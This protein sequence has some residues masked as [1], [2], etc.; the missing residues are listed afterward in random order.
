MATQ[1]YV[2]QCWTC[3]GEFDA[4]DSV[5]CSCDPRNPTRLCQFCLQCFCNAAEDY[6]KTFWKS[7]PEVLR[8]EIALL[9][10]AKGK[11]GEMLIR[12][13]L[14]TTDQLVKAIEYQKMRNLRM[15]EALVELGFVSRK[16]IDYFLS[17]QENVSTVNL[18]EFTP[19]AE[20]FA[21]LPP[22]FCHEKNVLPL[23]EDHVGDEVIVTVAMSDPKDV[24]LID[25]IQ[26]RMESK[27]IPY[28]AEMGAI[29]AALEKFFNK[30]EL[31]PKAEDTLD[32]KKA[33]QNLL[34]GGIKSKATDLYIEPKE[35]FVHISYRIDG[36][37]FKHKPFPISAYPVLLAEFRRTVNLPPQ[38]AGGQ[39]IESGRAVFSYQKKK[40]EITLQALPSPYGQSLGIK[41]ID[42]EEF[43]KDISALG[44]ADA[45]L[46]SLRR[47]LAAANGV[48]LVAGPVMNGTLTTMYSVIKHLSERG[49]RVVTI[50]SPVLSPLDEV[51]QIQV[52]EGQF[53]R[54]FQ[55]VLRTDPE[56]VVLSDLEDSELAVQVF[57]AGGKL[58]V[59]ALLEAQNA[60]D[61]LR[62]IFSSLGVSRRDAAASLRAIVSQ[63][64]IRK[65]CPDCRKESRIPP[66][67]LD[68]AGML[69]PGEKVKAFAGEG[70]AKCHH[71]G[72]RGRT[73]VFEVLLIS[74]ALSQAMLQGASEA[75]LV[76]L[77]RQAGM[78]SMKQRCFEAIQQ[79]ETTV[80][81]FEKAKF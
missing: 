22:R 10:G 62:E 71:T 17:R 31:A 52:S 11:L 80:E 81:E 72:Y 56:A 39:E 38:P 59:A 19:K 27:I 79:G 28:Q 53:A 64:L 74:E 42:R 37:L 57:R 5:W 65:I 60:E 61:A 55:S 21:K 20:L 66:V 75:E 68:R 13:N 18:D 25:L 51:Q 32:V 45:D 14:L 4:L 2:V 43:V 7:A 26:T 40:Y 63:R 33:T 58:T 1:T 23:D 35:Q 30:E 67:A 9:Q 47:A 34:I 24:T 50:E 78:V 69:R 49:R 8:K 76:A 70:C 6:K 73:P 16:D 15:G 12:S 36:M 46:R 44:L 41:I 29:R 77:A 54:A 48:T 3:L